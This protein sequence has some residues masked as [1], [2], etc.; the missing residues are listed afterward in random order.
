MRLIISIF[1][2]FCVSIS[3]IVYAKVTTIDEVVVEGEAIA[4][5]KANISV[6]S[7]TLPA[8]VNVITKEDLEKMPIRHYLD[9]FRKTPGMITSH[10]GQGDIADGFGMRGYQSGHGS[11][12]AIFVDGVPINIPH[13]SHSHGFA[14]IGWLVPEMIERI[15]VIKG[16]F[17][18]LY[19]N[20]ALGGVINIITKKSDKTPII[21]AELGSYD[22]YRGITTISRSDWKPTPFLLYEAY[23]KN[24][25]R[26]NSDYTRYNLFNKLTVPLLNGKLSI[27][28]HYVNRDW[29]APGYLSVDDVKNGTRK[30]TDAINPTDGGN[31]EYYNLVLNY[32]PSSGEAGPHATLYAA[33]EDLNRYATFPPSSQRL[34]HNER[35]F[36]GWNLLYNYMPNKNLSLIFGTDGRYDNGDRQRYNTTNRV[37]TSTTQN[38]HIE[39]TNIGL[40]FQ[41]QY[42]PVDFLKVVGGLR[43][44]I[45]RF[46]IENK[47][48]PGNSGSGDTSIFSPKIGFVIAPIKN[49]NIFANKGLGFRSPAADEMSPPD[50]DYKNFNLKPAKVDTWD[51]GFNT[52][53]FDKLHL[54]FDYY[55]TDMEREIRNVGADTIN[56]GKSK[57]DGY[58]I[59]AKIY[60]TN[61]LVIYSNYGWVKAKIK[62]PDTTGEDKITGVPKKYIGTGV[63]WQHSFGKDKRLLI[64]LGYQYL[65]KAPLNAAG[66][67]YRPPV[68]R[69][70]TKATYN[71]KEWSLFAESTYHPKK[72]A[73]EGM[74]LIGGVPVYDP[75][76]VWDVTAGIKY[77]F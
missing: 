28:V 1:L 18:A 62:N 22:A 48:R 34:E 68:D 8:S 5:D 19:G 42:R 6:K 30:R 51:I 40:F 67:I 77:K 15:E 12:V 17:S 75:K 64:D 29:G 49:L 73:S 13:H 50:K 38:W 72:Y 33:S 57:R 58:E 53:L 43:Y 27:R 54:L 25:Y 63:E 24:G 47:I 7:E 55:Q 56:I 44:D 46:D 60:A 2:M 39:E 37:Q 41:G 71:I 45:F 23:T 26:D 3:Q 20:F 59:E 36:Y 65:G 70:M 11:E 10:Y 76:P 14:D 61:D 32:T 66:T 74:F 35:V 52:L 4:E 16:P 21:G 31:S 9:M 69:Y